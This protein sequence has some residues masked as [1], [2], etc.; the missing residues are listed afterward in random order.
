MWQSVSHRC[1]SLK[2]I[3]SCWWWEGN[4]RE[5]RG[6]RRGDHHC[7]DGSLHRCSDRR[8][9][10]PPPAPPVCYAGARCKGKSV[11]F[12]PQWWVGSARECRRVQS[13]NP[14]PGSPTCPK[15]DVPSLA[16][17][18]F[19]SA[20]A[21]HSPTPILCRLSA[22]DAPVTPPTN[23]AP[24]LGWTGKVP[25]HHHERVAT[26][27]RRSGQECRKRPEASVVAL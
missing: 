27:H 1:I 18:D 26:V 4:G 5:R 24:L 6:G 20:R 11:R 25:E 8:S 12:T 17:S 10:Q 13:K 22:P 21:G 16:P 14:P 7:V 9:A 3:N 15:I 23:P 2:C 19:L